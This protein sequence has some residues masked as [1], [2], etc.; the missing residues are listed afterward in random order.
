MGKVI[1]SRVTNEV[2]G[3]TAAAKKAAAE[4]S[5]ADATRQDQI[6]IIC[7]KLGI[8]QTDLAVSELRKAQLT[9]IYSDR[10]SESIGQLFETLPKIRDRMN[11]PGKI[12]AIVVDLVWEAADKKDQ[13]A[14]GE[15]IANELGEEI[16][17]GTT[18]SQ[19]RSAGATLRKFS[20]LL[21]YP[22]S[23]RTIYRLKLAFKTESE[24]F[25]KAG[26]TVLTSK[27]IAR[28]LAGLPKDLKEKIE[29]GTHGFEN[30]TDEQM[31]GLPHEWMTTLRCDGE[32]AF[33]LKTA[34]WKECEL[35]RDIV[36]GKKKIGKRLPESHELSVA[37]NEGAEDSSSNSGSSTSSS[38]AEKESPQPS[39]E[40]GNEEQRDQSYSYE[41]GDSCSDGIGA[42]NDEKTE[43]PTQSFRSTQDTDISEGIDPLYDDT[44]SQDDGWE[45]TQK[46]S[47]THF[48]VEI[49]QLQ[50]SE[51]VRKILDILD[52]AADML[53]CSFPNTS[54]VIEEAKGK[55]DEA[56]QEE[57]EETN[58]QSTELEFHI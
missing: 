51:V 9:R 45:R 53:N 31:N 22:V 52:H 29:N 20:H 40:A 54:Q 39:D 58:H 37:E 30:A 16:L 26:T 18:L 32:V 11:L 44:E 24:P 8:N 25:F 19:L 6:K 42:Q 50:P 48:D 7:E 56:Y 14:L 17:E 38:D 33:N 36:D 47:S 49:D 12:K 5:E 41:N 55:I 1:K 57:V 43:V 35:L 23:Y 15:F 2:D 4:Q 10:Y 21:D 3:A 27:V 34:S 46:E 28:S 13:K